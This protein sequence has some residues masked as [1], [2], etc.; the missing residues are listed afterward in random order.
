MT[1]LNVP[2]KTKAEEMLERHRKIAKFNFEKGGR[3]NIN[4]V[5]RLIDLITEDY[6]VFFRFIIGKVDPRILIKT[7]KGFEADLSK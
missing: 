5:S 4:G 1:N 3:I 6:F 2:V 7:E